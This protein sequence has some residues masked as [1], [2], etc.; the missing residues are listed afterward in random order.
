MTS[1]ACMVQNLGWGGMEEAHVGLFISWKKAMLEESTDS[2][3]F[4]LA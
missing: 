1:L 3:I 4:F 2:H